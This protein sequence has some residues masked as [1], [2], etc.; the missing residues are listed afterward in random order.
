MY[1][2]RKKR[3]I[4]CK[5]YTETKL[6]RILVKIIPYFIWLPKRKRVVLRRHYKYAYQRR[7]MAD[8]TNALSKLHSKEAIT[9]LPSIN[10]SDYEWEVVT[11]FGI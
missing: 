2:C 10:L 11:C 4:K 1:F 3:P 6:E 5:V 8:M 9:T 7:L